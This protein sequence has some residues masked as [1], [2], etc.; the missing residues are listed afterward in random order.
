MLSEKIL[1]TTDSNSLSNADIVFVSVGLDFMKKETDLIT[2]RLFYQDWFRVKSGSLIVLETTVPPGTSEKMNPSLRSTI[3]DDDVLYVY[4][5]ERVMPG[6]NYLKSIEEL[7][8][9]AASSNKSQ[10]L[11]QSHLERVAPEVT[12]RM[13]KSVISAE[14]SKVLENSY[15]MINIALVQEFA[16]FSLILVQN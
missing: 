8:S 1:P 16:K 12:H 15:R 3:N 9:V 11:Y 10:L 4:S 2:S 14:L 7:P 6:P 13:L 5:Y